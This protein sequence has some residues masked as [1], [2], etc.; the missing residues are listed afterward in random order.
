MID[1]TN[2]SHS[3]LPEFNKEQL[4]KNTTRRRKQEMMA[5]NEELQDSLNTIHSQFLQPVINY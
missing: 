5:E 4:Q 1:A 3:N 2:P